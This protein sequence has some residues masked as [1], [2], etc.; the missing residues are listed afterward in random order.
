MEQAAEVAG[1]S[2]RRSVNMLLKS[3]T[4]SA[5]ISMMPLSRIGL[6]ISVGEES[7]GLL[8]CFVST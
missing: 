1:V 8:A 5:D 2:T 4:K 7:K 3:L 6:A